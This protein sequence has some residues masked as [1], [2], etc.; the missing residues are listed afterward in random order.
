MI[1]WLVNIGLIIFGQNWTEGLYY[2]GM[3]SSLTICI[4][5]QIHVLMIIIYF[6]MRSICARSH[7]MC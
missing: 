1:L 4:R 2:K 5:T 6:F 7:L 3:E